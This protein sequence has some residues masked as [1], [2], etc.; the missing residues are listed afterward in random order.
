MVTLIGGNFSKKNL[1]IIFILTITCVSSGIIIES[2]ITTPTG[3]TGTV[4]A[5]ISSNTTLTLAQSPY[6]VAENLLVEVGATLTI[7]PGVE[8]RFATGK[9]LVVDGGLIAEGVPAAPIVFTSNLS[10]P[11]KGCW[12]GIQFRSGSGRANAS[13]VT[14]AEFYHADE[15]LQDLVDVENNYFE[16]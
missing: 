8:V 6:Y 14:W 15:A 9:A 11:Y 12:G 16:S 2:V 13:S 4:P 10:S 1:G 5:I 3:I 7:E